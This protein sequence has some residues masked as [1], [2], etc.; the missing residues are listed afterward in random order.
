MNGDF[1]AT[2]TVGWLFSAGSSPV[3]NAS[4]GAHWLN[5]NSGGVVGAYAGTQACICSPRPT[6]CA[7]AAQCLNTQPGVRYV[8]SLWAAMGGQGPASQSLQLS[9]TGVKR[10]IAQVCVCVC[11]DAAMSRITL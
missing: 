10:V 2:P 5:F 8:L 3:V 1:F 7:C 9:A 11:G 4:A 6:G